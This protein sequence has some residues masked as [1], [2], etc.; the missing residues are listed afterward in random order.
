MYSKK[1][2]PLEL[3]NEIFSYLKYKCK[4]CNKSLSN[5]Y[6]NYFCSKACLI[7][8]YFK[9]KIIDLYHILFIIFILLLNFC[10]EFILSW[11]INCESIY[12]NENCLF[13]HYY[14]STVAYINVFMFFIFLPCYLLSIRDKND[15]Q[16]EY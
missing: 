13:L 5:P 7:Y 16:F 4:C 1:Y 12:I 6:Y 15:I 10:N 11:N 14:F 2:L 9:I 8:F 3:K